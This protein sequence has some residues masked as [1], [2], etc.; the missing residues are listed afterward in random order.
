MGEPLG[1]D[2]IDCTMARSVFTEATVAVVNI[3]VNGIPYA[4]QVF[5]AVPE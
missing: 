1:R 3:V 4:V 5:K 2:R